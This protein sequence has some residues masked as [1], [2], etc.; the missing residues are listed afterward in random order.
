MPAAPAAEAPAASEPSPMPMSTSPAAPTPGDAAAPASPAPADDLAK[1]RAVSSGAVTTATLEFGTSLQDPALRESLAKVDENGVRARLERAARRLGYEGIKV[2]VKAPAGA[3]AESVAGTVWEV[4]IHLPEADAKAVIDAAQAAVSQ[5]PI[6]PSS[7]RIGGLVAGNTQVLALVAMLVSCLAIVAY[8]WFRFHKVIYG[9][10]A[11]VALIHDVTITVGAMAVS[12]Y[13]TSV[14]GFLQVED[15]KIS[16][17]VVAALLTI[18]GYSI[19]DTIV[20]FDRIREVR[21]KIPV[22]TGDMINDSVNQTLSRTTLTSLLTLLSTVILYFFGGPSIHA[23]AF[24]I[25]I[26]IVVGTYSSIYIASPL[27]LMFEEPEA[28]SSDRAAKK[29]EVAV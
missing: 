4:T 29:K 1:I 6:F 10:A 21:G 18:V 5:R 13:L 28:G 15:F 24:A 23:F 22:L 16:L 20:I 14:L 3:S 27:L 25:C 17:A 2:E 19:N 11:V 9:L 7:S 12:V 8:V 26:G